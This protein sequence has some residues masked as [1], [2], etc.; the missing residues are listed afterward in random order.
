[1]KTDEHKSGSL[2]IERFLEL[3]DWRVMEITDD[4]PFNTQKICP[5]D[6]CELVS[7]C[8]LVGQN[9]KITIRIGMCPSCG[10]VGYIDRPAK[11]WISKFYAETWD[12]A[13]RINSETEAA[14]RREAFVK[15]GFSSFI[16]VRANQLERFLQQYSFSKSKPVL[17]IGCG[18]GTSLKFLEK[19]G[20]SKLYGVETSRHRAAIASQAYD[21]NVFTGAFED[22]SVQQSCRSLAPFGLITSHHVMEHVFNPGEVIRLAASLQ[23]EGDHLVISLPNMKGEP[24]MQTIL[25]WPHLHA[26]TKESFARLLERHGYE[27]LDDSFSIKREL[28]FLARKRGNNK[29]A[30]QSSHDN[31]EWV[32][33]KFFNA[34]GVGTHYKFPRR[35]LWWYRPLGL[36]HG[37]QIPFFD[38]HV[39]DSVLYSL[40]IGMD[41]VTR[42]K[43]KK[44]ERT[45]SCV[46]RD[47][48]MRYVLPSECPMEIQFEG[49][50]LMTYK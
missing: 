10:Y 6:D 39:L 1:M 31:H 27:V 25:Y 40:R 4:I 44:V 22:A 50:I 9:G 29:E 49:N 21:L 5:A 34:L 2:L 16:N 13:A 11:A 35:R 38:I 26:F 45:Q 41:K 42:K 36:D 17:E 8:A 37:G 15:N 43:R 48:S 23:E 14:V 19:F 12:N 32:R 28:F 20:F 18:Y 46:V 47:V 24:S 30:V 3:D 33:D 7:L